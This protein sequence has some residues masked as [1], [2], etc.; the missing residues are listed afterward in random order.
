MTYQR[1]YWQKCSKAEK[2][3]ADQKQYT[4]T[5]RAPVGA[6]K[7]FSTPI[8]KSELLEKTWTKIYPLFTLSDIIVRNSSKSMLPFPSSSTWKIYSSHLTPNVQNA[9]S[10]SP[11]SVKRMKNSKFHMC[12]CDCKKKYLVEYFLSGYC[13]LYSV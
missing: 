10:W 4:I 1:C 12:D 13:I 2:V 11:I 7:P 5:T 9:F 8:Y 6:N 3:G